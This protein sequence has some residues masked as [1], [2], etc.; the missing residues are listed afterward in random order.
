M[1]Q[2]SD[3]LS[4]KYFI[5]FSFT[6]MEREDMACYQSTFRKSSSSYMTGGSYAGKRNLS[7]CKQTCL[8]QS[9]CQAFDYNR[10]EE[11]CWLHY[12]VN[13]MMYYNID[14]DHYLKMRRP[15]RSRCK[16]DTV[17]LDYHLHT[18]KCHKFPFPIPM[19]NGT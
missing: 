7:A 16:Y 18:V 17:A 9:L 4:S 5:W 15:C 19:W 3:I 6:V 1:L 13:G 2:L 12:S 14:V 11:S 10:I 8:N